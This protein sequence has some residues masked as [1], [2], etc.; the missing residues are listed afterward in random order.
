MQKLLFFFNTT[1]D[2]LDAPTLGGDTDILKTT[3]KKK[4][5]LPNLFML[6]L[7]SQTLED[8]VVHEWPVVG[9]LV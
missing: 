5:T 3:I 2:H 4:I 9:S 7:D 6:P 1:E 8:L